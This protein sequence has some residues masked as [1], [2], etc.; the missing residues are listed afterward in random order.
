[1]K[2]YLCNVHSQITLIRDQLTAQYD[3][4]DVRMQEVK[5]LLRDV[6]KER[7]VEAL[8][9]RVRLLIEENVEEKVKEKVREQVNYASILTR[10][11]P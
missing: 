10:Q 1:M 5:T 7:L 3:R 4:Q 9:T 8:R 6:L 2:V 11:T